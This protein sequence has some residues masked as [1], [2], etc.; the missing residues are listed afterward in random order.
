MQVCRAWVIESGSGAEFV[1]DPIGSQFCIHSW[2][3]QTLDSQI[4]DE[5]YWAFRAISATHAGAVES[6]LRNATI[7]AGLAMTASRRQL[8]ILRNVEWPGGPKTADVVSDL[9]EGGQVLGIRHRETLRSKNAEEDAGRTRHLAARST[10]GPRRR[11]ADQF[12]RNS[13]NQRQ[14]P[15]PEPVASEPEGRCFTTPV[16]SA[17]TTAE[18]PVVPPVDE[19]APA[20]SPQTTVS[21]TIRLGVAK[22]ARPLSSS[23]PCASTQRSSPAPARAKTV[24]IW[25]LI[26][27]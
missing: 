3:R 20:V 21:T 15:E 16:V 1:L 24:M 19:P 13:G 14:N 18:T 10:T 9:A 25:R 11:P 12:A 17:E 27:G 23:R 2:L 4:D 22:S 26:E 6:R 5:Q 7:D 8:F